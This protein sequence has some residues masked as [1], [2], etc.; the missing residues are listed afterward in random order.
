MLERGWP[1]IADMDEQYAPVELF[2]FTVCPICAE[3]SMNRVWKQQDGVFLTLCSECEGLT[4]M[5]IDESYKVPLETLIEDWAMATVRVIFGISRWFA[6]K[7]RVGWSKIRP[8][9]RLKTS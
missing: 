7:C 5:D 2:A 6:G 3:Q 8:S 9:T 1:I 4:I